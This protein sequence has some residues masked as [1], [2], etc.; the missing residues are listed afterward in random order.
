MQLVELT[1]LIGQFCL[2]NRWFAVLQVPDE[3]PQ[4]EADFPAAYHANVP[5]DIRKRNEEIL[6]GGF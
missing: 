2:L 1:R 6:K 5:E 4:D 3:G